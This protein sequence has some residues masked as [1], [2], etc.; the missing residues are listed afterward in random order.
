[1]FKNK[2]TDLRLSCDIGNLLLSNHH[3]SNTESQNGIM[4]GA[5]LTV[6]PLI[7]EVHVVASL[8]SRYKK[9]FSSLS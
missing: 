2:P 6:L 9:A 5:G 1:M 4:N 7:T 3:Q 8:V